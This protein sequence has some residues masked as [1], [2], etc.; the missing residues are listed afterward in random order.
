MFPETSSTVRP[1]LLKRG[2]PGPGAIEVIETSGNSGVIYYEQIAAACS[3]DR[4]SCVQLRF[5]LKALLNARTAQAAPGRPGPGTAGAW[6]SWRVL[7]VSSLAGRVRRRRSKR[8][9][10]RPC[11]AAGW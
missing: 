2:S 3:T 10:H 6:L 4:R 7:V 9:S 5:R 11:G 8:G 1:A